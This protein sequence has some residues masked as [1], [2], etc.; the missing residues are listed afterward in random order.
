LAQ[1]VILVC[2]ARPNFM[3]VAMVLGEM[4]GY[5]QDFNPLLVHTGQHYDYELSGAFF[6]DLSLPEPDIYLGVG[7]ANHGEQTGRIMIEFEKVVE[8]EKPSLIVVVGDVNSTLAAAVVASKVMIPLAHVEA[9]LRSYDRSMPEEINRM[10]TDVL[11]DYC[12]TTE[13]DANTN[14]KREGVDESKVFLVGDVMIDCVMKTR[15]RAR[16]SKI[17]EALNLEPG[18]YAL[19]TLHRPSNVDSRETLLR[20]FR[21]LEVIRQRI[22]IVFPVHPRTKNR[23][24]QFQIDPM[25]LSIMDPLGYLD[26]LM[27]EENAKFVLTDSGSIQQETTFFG[28]PCLTIR[29]NTERPFTVARGTNTLVGSDPDRIV[30]ESFNVMDGKR[31]KTEVHQL[32]DGKASRRIVKVLKDASLS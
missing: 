18:R 22:P 30:N 12:F 14:L 31:T 5:P 28:V 9:G 29:K 17:L 10:V 19:L 21:A 24:A 16:S 27:L 6:K 8:R 25:N 15:E 3:K 11:S 13:E 23:L 1:K 20:I 26:F 32:W 4:R 7:S 2:G